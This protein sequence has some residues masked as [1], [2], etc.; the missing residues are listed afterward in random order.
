LGPREVAGWSREAPSL[1]AGRHDSLEV[2]TVA[3]RSWGLQMKSD[4]IWTMTAD[5][6]IEALIATILLVRKQTILV[7]FSRV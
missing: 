7:I 3:S 5:R 4:R 2:Q 6:P 1:S